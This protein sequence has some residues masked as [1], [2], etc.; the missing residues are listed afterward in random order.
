MANKFFP[1]ICDD[2]SPVVISA[3]ED[4]MGM[5]D[6]LVHRYADLATSRGDEAPAAPVGYDTVELLNAATVVM[7]GVSFDT[8]ILKENNLTVRALTISLTG[9]GTTILPILS[10]RIWLNG[11]TVEGGDLLATIEDAQ[12]SLLGT[13]PFD[14]GIQLDGG[15]F[16]SITGYRGESKN[17]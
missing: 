8:A 7:D 15:P 2:G 4:I 14:T 5:Y 16:M 17:A 12:L 3:D 1:Y 13:L 10:N 11:A 6:T 9:F